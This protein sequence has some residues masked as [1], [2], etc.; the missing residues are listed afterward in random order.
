[1]SITERV[2]RTSISLPSSLNRR[3]RLEAKARNKPASAIVRSALERYFESEGADP[4]P[5]FT[6]IGASG[7]RD[8]S[9]R[10]EELLKRRFRRKRRR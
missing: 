6:G 3:L 1:M 4:L 8:T 2:A 7:R 10:A 9:E 5:S